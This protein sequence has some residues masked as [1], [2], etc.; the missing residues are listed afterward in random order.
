MLLTEDL[1]EDRVRRALAEDLGESGDVTTRA[2]LLHPRRARARI[3]AKGHGTVAGLDVAEAT[4]R[5]LDAD[6]RIER[7][8]RDGERV[9]PGDELLRIDGDAAAML[10]AERTALNFLQRLCGIATMTRRYVDA[11]AGT[12]ARILETR[13]T[14]PGLRQLEKYA[15][16]VGGGTPHRRGLY[17]QVLLKENHF[18]CAAPE[19]YEQVVARVVG[20]HA[21]PSP[22]VI[23]EARDP[24]EAAAAVRGGAGVVMLD[25]FA[26]GPGLQA[27]VASLRALAQVLGRSVSIEV[28]GGVTL[29]TVRRFAECGVDRI[30]VGALTHSV[31]A[32][33]LSLLV[34]VAR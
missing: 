1:V 19:S 15:V 14:T 5:A 23:A 24:E 30:S 18:A 4:F 17:D 26:P 33:D 2:A 21:A 7:M 3:V 13:K 31:P 16:E 28:S 25:N 34:E 22:V 20:T 8:T 29:D 6:A 11:V 12:G 32:L 27:V 9:A 10:A